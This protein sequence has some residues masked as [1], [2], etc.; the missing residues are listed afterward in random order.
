MTTTLG[1]INYNTKL[2]ASYFHANHT[3]GYQL[4]YITTS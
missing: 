3:Q 4:Q 1:E 2:Q